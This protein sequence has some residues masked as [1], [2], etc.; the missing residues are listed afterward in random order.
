MRFDPRIDI[1]DS[2]HLHKSMSDLA[3]SLRLGEVETLGRKNTEIRIGNVTATG[4]G[5]DVGG[6]SE[7]EKHKRD[8]LPWKRIAVAA[9]AAIGS[10]AALL[11]RSCQ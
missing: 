8:S 10:A 4:A 7:N 2:S 5:R 1:L 9:I 3:T 11:A 6:G